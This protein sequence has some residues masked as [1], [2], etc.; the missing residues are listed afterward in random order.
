MDWRRNNWVR[1]FSLILFLLALSGPIAIAQ[2]QNSTKW[3]KENWEK[4][5]SGIEYKQ[6]KQKEKEE[7]NDYQDDNF[8][9]DFSEA[10][11][12]TGLG[13]IILVVL[14]ISVFAFIIYRLMLSNHDARLKESNAPQFSLE[15][16]EENLEKSDIDKYLDLALESSDFRTATRLLFLKSIKN[17]NSLEL[18]IWRKDKTNND[19]LN[20]MRSHKHYK[21]FRDL[22]LAYEIVWYG[23]HE[24]KT[25]EFE[26]IRE[27][28]KK[29]EL[30]LNP[31]PSDEK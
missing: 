29:F 27:G 1:I 6:K 24:V 7:S 20:E 15:Y 5:K 26:H 11:Y 28:F 19:F 13:K 16:I 10:W 18:I 3:D 31:K 30:L 17:L 22:T 14:L 25:S 21:I 2:E 12:Q 4:A 23:D 9:F 8:D